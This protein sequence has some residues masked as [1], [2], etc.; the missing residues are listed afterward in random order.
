MIEKYHIPPPD[1]GIELVPYQDPTATCEHRFELRRMRIRG[2]GVQYKNQCTLCGKGSPA[3]AHDKLSPAAREHAPLYDKEL[4]Q[5]VREEYREKRRA[6]AA[7]YQESYSD[8]WW[9]WYTEYLSSPVWQRRRAAVLKRS[10]YVC[11]ACGQGR[12]VNAHHLTYDNV[13]HE[14]LYE[15]VAVCA[16]CHDAIHEMRLQ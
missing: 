4:E 6:I 11:E 8:R 13:G 1:K 10:E 16:N 7:S 5:N 9:A 12:A 3:I 15:L 14:P 2:G